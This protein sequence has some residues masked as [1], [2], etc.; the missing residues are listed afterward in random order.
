M[1]EGRVGKTYT[2]A[3]SGAEFAAEYDVGDAGEAAGCAHWVGLGRD[4]EAWVP[5][6]I[7]LP[8]PT[9]LLIS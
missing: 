7:V 1:A 3:E 9:C 5:L 8:L 4:P 6:T 2:R